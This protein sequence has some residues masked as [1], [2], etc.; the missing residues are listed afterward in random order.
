VVIVV[1]AIIAWLLPVVAAWAAW[2]WARGSFRLLKHGGRAPG[3]VT[4]VAGRR[5]DIQYVVD[6]VTHQITSQWYLHAKVGTPVTVLYEPG[7]PQKG[8]LKYWQDL[9]LPAILWTAAAVFFAF[10]DIW[11]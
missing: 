11:Y 1:A 9:W 3:R 6:D 8:Y 10:L 7:A 4:A 5:C 2:D